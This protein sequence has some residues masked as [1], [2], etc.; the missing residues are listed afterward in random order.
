MQFIFYKKHKKNKHI[1]V[2]G[3]LQKKKIANPPNGCWALDQA[4]PVSARPGLPSPTGLVAL[5]RP[6]GR[7]RPV[8]GPGPPKGK[9]G[10]SPLEPQA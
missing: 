10:A 2:S 1:P 7:A 5:G 3:V 8:S 6:S 9:P 4:G